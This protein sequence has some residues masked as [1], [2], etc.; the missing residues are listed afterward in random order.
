MHGAISLSN[1]RDYAERIVNRYTAAILSM[2]DT[3]SDTK[4]RER[5][6]RTVLDTSELL[7]RRIW[8]MQEGEVECLPTA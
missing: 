1:S 4:E 3:L 5:M 2:N 6:R 8:D 7:V